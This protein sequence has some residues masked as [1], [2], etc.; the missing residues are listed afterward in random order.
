MRAA[1]RRGLV[2]AAVRLTGAL[3]G[4]ALGVLAGCGEGGT[5]SAVG[6]VVA[7]R[8][9]WQRTPA[10]PTGGTLGFESS[11]QVPPSVQTI[12]VRV[13]PA[14][15]PAERVFVQPTGA[16]VTVSGIL[17]GVVTVQ[18]FGYDVPF[19]ERSEIVSAALPP[20]FASGPKS[21]EVVP[22][23][24]TDAGVFELAARPFVTGFD[25]VPGAIGVSRLSPVEFVIATA[26]GAVDPEGIDVDIDG[27]AI[28][29]SGESDPQAGLIPCDDKSELP[30]SADGDRNLVGFRF[31]YDPL[32]S[33]P[34]E[35]PVGVFVSAADFQ[36]ISVAYSYGFNTTADALLAGPGARARGSVK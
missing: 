22:Y 30:C 12:E 23:A 35:A 2:R 20:S 32:L 18:L 29:R 14:G 10:D 17:P 28:V 34:P 33:Y 3:I 36:G 9:V 4:A 25:P 1:K 8:A 26:V 24:V 21:V 13:S 15:A 27:L 11:T 31:F 6:S 19:A 7:M 16:S 5:P